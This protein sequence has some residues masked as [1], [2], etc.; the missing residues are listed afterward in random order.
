[1]FKRTNCPTFK[2]ENNSKKRTVSISVIQKK[3]MKKIFNYY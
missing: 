2:K 1:M 3:K